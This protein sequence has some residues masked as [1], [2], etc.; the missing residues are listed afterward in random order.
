MREYNKVLNIIITNFVKPKLPPKFINV[1][2]SVYDGAEYLEECL[3][4]IQA[5]TYKNFR[6]LLGIDGCKKSLLK[7]LDIRHKYDNLEIYYSPKNGGVYRMFNALAYLVDEEEY[8]QFFGADDVM[9]PEMLERMEANHTHTI[10]RH[11]GVLMIKAKDFFEMGGYRDWRCGADSDMICR[12]RLKY[13]YKE[14]IMPLLF[15]RRIHDKQLTAAKET[16]YKSPLREKY[17]KI[18]MD[19]YKSKNPITY[20]KPVKSKIKPV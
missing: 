17:E 3:D 7:A 9:F 13:K 20:I 19:N 12:L 11:A 14:K 1:I 6:I 15:H 10:S 5:Q 16:A 4:S 2:I 18:T 8:L